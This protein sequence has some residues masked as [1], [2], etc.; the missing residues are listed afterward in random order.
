VIVV[1]IDPGI[2][3][4]GVAVFKDGILEKADHVQNIWGEG[5]QAMEARAMAREVR[6][7]VEGVLARQGG[8]VGELAVEWPRV[9]RGAKSKGDNND[10]LA[11]AAVDTAVAAIFPDA[12]VYSYYPDEWKGQAL[13][14]V[15]AARVMARLSEYERDQIVLHGRGTIEELAVGKLVGGRNHNTLDAIGI[16]LFHVGRFDRKRVFAR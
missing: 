6:T 5:N 7:F 16:G 13:K 14:E 8:A 15:I 12:E 1:A 4:C 2:R 11:L 10:L 3:A 9:Y